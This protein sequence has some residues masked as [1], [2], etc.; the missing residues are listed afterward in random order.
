MLPHVS[1]PMENPTSPAAVAAPGPEDEPP[2]QWLVFQGVRPAPV[3][4]AVP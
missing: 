1:D 3:E 2:A 4:E